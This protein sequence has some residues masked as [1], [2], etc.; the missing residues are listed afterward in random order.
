VR[1][2]AYLIIFA[3]HIAS[4]DEPSIVVRV[5]ERWQEDEPMLHLEERTNAEG[6]GGSKQRA[7]SMFQVGPNL[8]AVTTGEWWSNDP[9]ADGKPHPQSGE[10]DNEARGWR[11]KFEATYDVGPFQVTGFVAAGHVDSAHEHGT[12]RDI[13]VSIGKRFR[14]SRWMLAWLGLTISQREW[15]GDNGPPPGERNGPSVMLGFST[16]FR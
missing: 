12:Y 9:F 11:A 6:L 8:R 13:G 3:A 4:A 5:P 1:A 16:T 7:T 2:F 15:L 10:L 14:L